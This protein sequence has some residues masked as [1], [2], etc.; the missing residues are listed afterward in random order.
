MPNW[1]EEFCQTSGE[2][3][4]RWLR[5]NLDLG[6]FSKNFGHRCLKEFDLVSERWGE[7]LTP[8][9]TTLQAMLSVNTEPQTQVVCTLSLELVE[10]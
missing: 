9:V 7:N 2:E 4:E 6:E 3:A 10:T 8:V 1:R 5:A